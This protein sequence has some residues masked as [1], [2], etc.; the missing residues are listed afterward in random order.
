MKIFH[1]PRKPLPPG[2]V[3]HTLPQ[4]SS[5][6]HAEDFFNVLCN[7]RAGLCQRVSL[8]F[9]STL[10]SDGHEGITVI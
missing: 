2:A 5:D 1:L 10:A 3:P 6:R 4:R 7:E 9:Q 8:N